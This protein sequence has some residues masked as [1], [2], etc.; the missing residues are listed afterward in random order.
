MRNVLLCILMLASWTGLSAQKYFSMHFATDINYL[1][2]ADG[3]AL[4]PSAFTT[5][6]FGLHYASYKEASG[7][8][9]GLNVNYKDG[10]GQGFPN[11]PVVMR[12]WGENQN[13]GN[14]SVEMD[15]KVGPRIWPIY[16]KI[17]YILGY[18][19]TQT[20]FTTDGEEVKLNPIY[21][22]LPFGLSMN[23]PTGYGL[24]GFGAFYNVGV[25]NVV[26]NPDPSTGS[27]YEGGRHRSIT[28]EMT[29][30]FES[31]N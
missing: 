29:V 28:V 15:V 18:R 10:D 11:L 12:D 26:G 30:Y 8:E 6:K 19:F 1:T 21:L 27:L 13:V 24:V 5:G 3:L 17:G 2:Q 20:G 25:L 23:W 4:A 7:F 22:N 9:L 14:F 16:P 31:G